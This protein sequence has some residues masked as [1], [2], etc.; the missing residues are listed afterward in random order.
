MGKNR[1]QV[2]LVIAALVLAGFYLYPTLRLIT[3]SPEAKEAMDADALASLRSKALRLGLD[4]QGGMHLVMEVDKSE[5]SEDEAEDALDRA[6]EVIRNRVDQFGVSEPSIQKQGENRILVQLPGVQDAHQAKELIGQT[7]QLE[8]MMLRSAADFTE[9]LRRVDEVL[10][11]RSE[12]GRKAA[13]EAL[14]EETGDEAAASESDTAADAAD[15]LFAQPDPVDDP[16]A[17]TPLTSKLRFIQGSDQ[18][19]AWVAEEDMIYVES[20][21][22]DPAVKGVMPFGTK[23]AFGR[24]WQLF[25]DG[26]RMKPLYLLTDRAELTGASIANAQVQLGLDASYPN[27]PGVALT[28]TPEGAHEFATLTENNIGRRLA[29]VLDGNVQSAPG[30]R[31]RIPRG[32]ASITGGFDMENASLLSI[33]LRAGALPAPLEIVEER[34][35]GPSLGRDS[36]QQG[37]RAALLGICLVAVF[38]IIYYRASGIL[39]DLALALNLV[40]IM[41]VMAGLKATL[42]LPGIAGVILTIGMAVD[43]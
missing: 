26:T 37:V 18:D 43:A 36:I 14:T 24:E 41:A 16:L 5:L 38:M 15:D 35:G 42:T 1:F 22:N 30:I 31:N 19:Q 13:E 33:V 32:N 8:F 21:L 11:S 9:T 7:A 17:Q 39:A 10:Y 34:T 23:F 3:L 29:I 28:M 40:F 12:A 2:L 4:L 27:Q 20:T 25:Q 6:L